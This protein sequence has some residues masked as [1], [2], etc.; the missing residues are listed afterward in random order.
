MKPWKSI[1]RSNG[2]PAWR[3]LLPCLLLLVPLAACGP[4]EEEAELVELEEDAGRPPADLDS[5]PV[6]ETPPERAP[7]GP[8]LEAPPPGEGAGALEEE[9]PVDPEELEEEL[10]EA[11]PVPPAPAPLAVA[12][13]AAAGRDVFLAQGCDGCHGVSSADIAGKTAAG[14]DLTGVG[15]RL[16]RA[17]LAAVLQGEEETANGKRHPKRFSGTPADLDALIDWLL[18]QE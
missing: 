6:E 4:G 7:L 3:T 15:E 17:T 8:E 12:E 13:T 18:A 10:D 5:A 2:R 9:M 1:R 14:G 16:E 11:E